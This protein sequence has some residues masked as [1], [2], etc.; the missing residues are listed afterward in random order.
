[1]TTDVPVLLT[2]EKLCKT[3][4]WLNNDG[5]L[6]KW[7]VY[8]L[9]EQG[10]APPHLRIERRIYFAEDAVLRWIREQETTTAEA[11]R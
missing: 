11:G 6:Q 5:E 4:G 3:L 8:E 9:V 10:K 7:K 1:M 2:V